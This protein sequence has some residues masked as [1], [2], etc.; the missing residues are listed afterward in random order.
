MIR[1]L[2]PSEFG[3][4][5]QHLLRLNNSDRRLRFCSELSDGGIE[6]HVDRLDP[7]RDIVF[8][9]FEDGELH[10][11]AEL[12]PNHPFLPSSAEAAFSVDPDQRRRGIASALMACLLKEAAARLIPR[13]FLLIRPENTAMRHLAR[14][15]GFSLKL[16]DGEI[17]AEVKPALTEREAAATEHAVKPACPPAPAGERP[18][19]PA[20]QSRSGSR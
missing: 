6:S 20:L 18:S 5:K 2:H 12:T 9:Y 17:F 1:A 8:G 3:L 7:S 4:V 13:V 15:F 11:V 10:G 19:I 16:E 14:K